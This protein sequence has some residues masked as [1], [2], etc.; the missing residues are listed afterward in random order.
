MTSE[1]LHPVLRSW[2]LTELQFPFDLF[3]TRVATTSLGVVGL[4]AAMPSATGAFGLAMYSVSKSIR[5][6]GIRM[7]LGAQSVY[8]MWS[9]LGGPNGVVDLRIGPVIAA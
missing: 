6:F 3:P 2:L 9:A 8:V 5:E 1:M 4:L 7:A